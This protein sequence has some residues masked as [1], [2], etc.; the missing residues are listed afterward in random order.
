MF[1]NVSGVVELWLPKAYMR[2]LTPN[3]SVVGGGAK[4]E[5]LRACELG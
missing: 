1:C 2:N 3:A 5:V 4:W